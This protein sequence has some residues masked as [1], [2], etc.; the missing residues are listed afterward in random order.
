PVLEPAFRKLSAYHPVPTRHGMTA[1]ELALFA[2]AEYDIGCDLQV[3]TCDGWT[4]EQWF[5]ETGLPWVNPSPNLRNLTQVTLYSAI[6]GFEASQMSVGRGTES[7]FEVFGAPYIDAPELAGR[8]NGV[9]DLHL[10]FVPIQFTPVSQKFAGE[11]CEGCFVFTTDRERLRPVE[12]NVRIACELARLY[13]GDM[14]LERSEWLLG[15]P[16][17]AEAIQEGAPATEII[18]AWQPELE[19]YLQRRDHY[20]LY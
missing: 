6:A 19:Q 20:L 2:N 15:G 18:A 9:E 8:L 14:D 4:R 17:V 13:P 7:P 3:I 1:A 5:D 12:A 11:R 10:R 16:R